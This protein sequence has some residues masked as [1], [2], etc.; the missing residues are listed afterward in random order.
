MKCTAT[1]RCDEAAEYILAFATARVA[2]GEFKEARY[3]LNQA[4]T[5]EGEELCTFY[6]ENTFLYIENNWSEKNLIKTGAHREL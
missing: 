3:E 1:S 6:S 5:K 2:L 4:V